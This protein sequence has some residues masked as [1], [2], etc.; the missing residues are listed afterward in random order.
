MIGT[1]DQREAAVADI[2]A[3]GSFPLGNT[4][5]RA[6]LV[7]GALGSQYVIGPAVHAVPISRDRWVAR[8]AL[9]AGAQHGPRQ[10]KFD[11]FDEYQNAFLDYQKN[12][13]D[14]LRENLARIME[15]DEA[16]FLADLIEVY[17]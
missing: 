9:V 17:R 1:P 4:G 6:R 5:Y 12:V 11:H 8:Q 13:M 3:D 16:A 14:P 7:R 10:E 15:A 2:L